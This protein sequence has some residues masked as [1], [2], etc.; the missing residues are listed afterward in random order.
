MTITAALPLH[1]HFALLLL[2]SVFR[3]V[4]LFV[5]T[6]TQRRIAIGCQRLHDSFLLVWI[7][8]NSS[9]PSVCQS[10]VIYSR[11]SPIVILDDRERCEV[12]GTNQPEGKRK[13]QE[14]EVCCYC[15]LLPGKRR[16]PGSWHPVFQA[17]LS[18]QRQRH[19]NREL[20]WGRYDDF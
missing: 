10:G 9:R 4:C 12:T 15:L 8:L 6:W 20:K 17:N 1:L 14:T 13:K 11:W 19:S 2:P 7:W 3:Q 18:F 16:A 5:S